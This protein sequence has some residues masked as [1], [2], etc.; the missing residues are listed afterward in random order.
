MREPTAGKRPS[1]H[2]QPWILS[3]PEPTTFRIGI[4]LGPLRRDFR[5]ESTPEPFPVP[6]VAMVLALARGFP[7]FEPGP[8]HVEFLRMACLTAVSMHLATKQPA[9]HVS[10]QPFA[11]LTERGHSK[12]AVTR[13]PRP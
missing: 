11:N 12:S 4:E 13:R 7:T 8:V 9:S 2:P 1:G 5:A 3:N 10:P 6:I